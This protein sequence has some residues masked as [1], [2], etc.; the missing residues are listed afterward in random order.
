MENFWWQKLGFCV[1]LHGIFR[2]AG[3]VISHECHLGSFQ[4][5]REGFR[6]ILTLEDPQWIVLIAGWCGKLAARGEK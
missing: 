3:N 2:S 1:Q 4:N 5:F 6:A